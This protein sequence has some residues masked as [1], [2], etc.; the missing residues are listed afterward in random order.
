[1]AKRKS[2]SLQKRVGLFMNGSD[3]YV[4]PDSYSIPTS[5][6]SVAFWWR[7]TGVAANDRVVDQQ[8]A[9]PTNGFSLLHATA[10][11]PQISFSLRNGATSVANIV[12]T[13]MKMGRFNFVVATYTVDSAKLFVNAVQQG[14][15]DSSCTMIAPSATLTFGR[16]SG[17]SNYAKGFLDGMM[18]FNK[19]LSQDEIDSL[20]SGSDPTA[21]SGLE[22]FYKFD[23]LSGTTIVDSS[24]NGRNGTRAGAAGTAWF[25]IPAKPLTKGSR[26]DHR[27]NF[28][29]LTNSKVAIAD[30]ASIRPETTNKFT[31]AG[32][33]Y[34]FDTRENVLPRFWEKGAQFWCFM[35]D[36]TNSRAN[37]LA[38]EISN[39]DS[40]TT[41][42]WGSTRFKSHRPYF[43]ATTFD[44]SG[45]G[46]CQHYVNGETEAMTTLLGPF[47]EIKSTSGSDMLLGN[48]TSLSRNLSGMMSDFKF[49]NVVL[50]Q[51]E[52]K[53]LMVGRRITRGL[54]VDLVMDEGSGSTLTDGSGGG[55]NGTITDATW[56]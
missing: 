50:T 23:E 49:F 21:L 3:S 28:A 43:I 54:Q 17:A 12:S 7:P 33:I 5:A 13:D 53:Q 4:T 10:N 35:G 26:S 38:L 6:F 32:W 2:V 11:S 52:I 15:T 18:I 22:L 56:E 40:S 36:Q 39:S 9:G 44:G 41:E 51:S 47:S 31:L 25:T 8:D 46:V 20:Y 24:G 14:S 48:R 45:A 55:H 19:V 1:M 16:R 30:A 29:K 34:L 37:Q 42:Y 27:L